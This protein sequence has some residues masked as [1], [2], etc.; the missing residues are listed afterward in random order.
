MSDNLIELKDL[1]KTF[2]Q[3]TRE[4]KVLEGVNLQIQKGQKVAIIGP[5]GSG[6][7]TLLDIISGVTL[8]SKGSVEICSQMISNS[9]SNERAKL[10]LE[11]IGFVFQNFHLFSH[12]TALENILFPLSLKGIPDSES[13]AIDYLD[14]VGLSHRKD[15]LPSEMSGGERQR[16]AIA[17]ALAVKPEVLIADEPSGSLDV[18]NGNKIVDLF[19]Q[20]VD[21]QKTTLIL[22]THNQELAEKCEKVYSITGG[23]LCLMD[24]DKDKVQ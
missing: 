16:V 2:L 10:R 15:H 12:F 4:V 20:L 17:R 23:T 14:K 9:N 8:P 7:S 5:S 24:V 22:V 21:L 18:E 13:I 19:F 6:K 11:K 3:G 1:G